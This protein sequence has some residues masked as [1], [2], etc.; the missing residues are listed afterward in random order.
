MTLTVVGPIQT[1]TSRVLWCLEELRVPYERVDAAPHSPDVDALNPLRQVPI[2]RDGDQVFTDS[3]AILFHL[4]DKFGALTYPLGTPERTRMMARINFLLT[5]IEAHLW[6]RSRHT[7]VLP[8]TA[9][10]AEASDIAAADFRL[11]EPKFSM[12]LGDSE[13]FGGDAFTIADIVATHCL[14]WAT[15]VGFGPLSE[16]SANYRD[17]MNSRPAWIASRRD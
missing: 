14:V 11:A 7:Y 5:E 6:L 8:E 9:R 13:F 15:N 16:N 4:A 1:R 3:I 2:L 12:L 10:I 17:R